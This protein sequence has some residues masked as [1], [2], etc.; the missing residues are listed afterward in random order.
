MNLDPIHTRI[1]NQRFSV[2]LVDDNAANLSRIHDLL[3]K[4]GL[5]F[6]LECA[7]THIAA[8]NAFARNSHDV[9]IIDSPFGNAVSILREA[10]TLDCSVPM[11]VLT[12]D[13]GREV[14]DAM[15]NNAAD[16]I[17]RSYLSPTVLERAICLVLSERVYVNFRTRTNS[18]TWDSSKTPATSFTRTTWKV[19]ILR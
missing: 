15:R 10:S 14:S 4:S 7:T 11:I 2:L 18:V 9:A 16:C 17:V 19:T 12:S 6:D 8:L 3:S 13:S 5:E 1:G